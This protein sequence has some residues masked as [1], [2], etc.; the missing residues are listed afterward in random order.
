MEIGHSAEQAPGRV[1]P[2]SLF[3]PPSGGGAGGLETLASACSELLRDKLEIKGSYNL[4]TRG[5]HKHKL[6]Y[7]LS[8]VCMF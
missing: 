5:G 3:F 8:A 6:L 4:W 7:L 2:Q 1:D